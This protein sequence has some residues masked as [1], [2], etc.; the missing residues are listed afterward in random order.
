VAYLD[1]WRG[2]AIG[3]VLVSHFL[4][5]TPW[6]NSGLLGVD[7]FFCLSGLLMSRLLF[8]RRMDLKTFYKRRASRILPVFF[9]FVAVVFALHWSQ[10]GQIDF[11]ELVST[12]LF[13]RTYVPAVPDIWHSPL[14]IGHLWS[15]NV[16]EH[17]YLLMGL[18]TLVA[19]LRGREWL[20][21]VGA[22]LLTIVVYVAYVK[23]PGIVPPW[24]DAGTEAVAGPLLLSA[25]YSLLSFRVAP[26]V[27]PWMPIAAFVAAALCFSS[28]LPRWSI[29]LVAPFFLAFAVN[30]LDATYSVVRAAL[31]W[32]PL[33]MLGVWSFSIYI[34][35][36]P[37]HQ[38][39]EHFPFGSG[40]AAAMVVGVLSFT[41]FENPVR[42]WL[43]R[44]W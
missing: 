35:Q 17:C 22:G 42:E 27:R 40:L 33:R 41:F 38:A 28:L 16:E 8:V 21:L 31:S 44:N 12:T 14:A 11:L 7:I 3:L 20:A 29:V 37:I 36:Q 39:Q 34:W 4:P 43:N 15:L 2:L 18:L 23:I 25:G 9:L 26:F 24:G 1:G 32:A 13:L 5:R 10:T 6:F 19:T 30:H